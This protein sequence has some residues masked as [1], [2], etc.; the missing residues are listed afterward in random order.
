MITT[1][2][3]NEDNYSVI[4]ITIIIII[5]SIYLLSLLPAVPNGVFVGTLMLCGIIVLLGL[6]LQQ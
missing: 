1:N 2:N 4:I 6:M 5:I 3:N